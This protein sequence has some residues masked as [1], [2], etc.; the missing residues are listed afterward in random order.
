MNKIEFSLILPCYNEGPTFEKSVAKIFSVL[1][2]LNLNSEIIFVEDKST[3]DTK[4]SVEQLVTNNKNVRAI[5]HQ[6]NEGRGKSVNDGIKASHGEIC[7]YIDVDCE[8]SPSYIP[9][10]ILEVQKGYGLVV[11][12]RFYDVNYKSIIRAILSKGYSKMVKVLINTPLDDTECGYKFFNKQLILPVLNKV[13]DKRWF[14]DTEI[15]AR[16]YWQNLKVGQV[17]VL[18]KKNLKKKSTVKIVPDTIDYIR[19]LIKFRSEFK[20]YK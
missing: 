12:K 10:F 9:L 18:F 4:K 8:V 19:R 5:Y 2:N 17:P 7:G 13:E 1:K 20:K 15:C 11:G 6:K 14:W 16:S 3:D